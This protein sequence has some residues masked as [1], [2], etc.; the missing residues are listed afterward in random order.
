M[1]DGAWKE[2]KGGRPR[3]VPASVLVEV[4]AEVARRTLLQDAF[5]LPE[6][7]KELKQGVKRKRQENGENP[8]TVS[9]PADRTMRNYIAEMKAVVLQNPD[10]QAA[11]P[12]LL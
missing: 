8:H 6:L 1:P 12:V 3:I 7:K 11:R 2:T 4:Q 10:V 5:S 9:E